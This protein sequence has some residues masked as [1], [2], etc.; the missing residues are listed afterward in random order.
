M[1]PKPLVRFLVFPVLVFVAITAGQATASPPAAAADGD[2]AKALH[3]FF[4]AEW[5]YLMEQNPTWASSLGDRRWNDRWDD[6]SL[7]AVAKREDHARASLA[8]FNKIERANLAPADQLN[9]DLFKKN[10]EEQIAGF[11]FRLYLLPI[12][13]RGGIQTADELGDQLRFQT[14]KDYEDWIARLKALPVSMDQQIVLMREGAK[15]R[16]MWPKIVLER[17]P[18]QIDKQIVENPEESPF[19]KPFKKFPDDIAAEDRERLTK[20]AREAIATDVIP[21]F[22]KLKTYFAGEY[23][24][25]AFDQVGCGRCRRGTSFTATSRGSSPPPI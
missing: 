8:R 25:A 20:A 5:D 12:N 24:P 4:D 7:E 19:F 3:R 16:V 22:Q 21:A 6:D 18:N 15:A 17:V 13:Q 14:V 2:S 1:N 11:K 10:L 23:L 9:F